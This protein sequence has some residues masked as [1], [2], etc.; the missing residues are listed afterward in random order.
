MR[1]RPWDI[2]CGSSLGQ[3][4]R[5]PSGEDA[6]RLPAQPA[7]FVAAQGPKR[8]GCGV[9]LAQASRCERTIGSLGQ[10]CPGRG[11]CCRTLRPSAEISLMREQ[12]PRTDRDR[13]RPVAIP[14]QLTNQSR[15]DAQRLA[16]YL[17]NCVDGE[18][19]AGALSVIHDWRSACD[20]AT[21]SASA[22]RSGARLTTHA[23][24]KA[25]RRR[26]RGRSRQHWPAGL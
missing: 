7:R 5:E 23:A 2:C 3:V 24:R 15:S 13:D 21:V 10:G 18:T 17:W 9:R 19:P 4:S 6:P 25:P 12:C 11:T 14:R 8:I 20:Q 26:T 1:D 22:V 16:L